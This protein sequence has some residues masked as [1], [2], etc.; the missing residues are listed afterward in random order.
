MKL[1]DR[2]F[3]LNNQEDIEVC[4]SS[5]DKFKNEKQSCEQEVSLELPPEL[6][7]KKDKLLKGNDLL[8]WSLLASAVSLLLYRAGI[9]SKVVLNYPATPALSLP[10]IIPID[11]SLSFKESL[12]QLVITSSNGLFLISVV[13]KL[14]ALLTSPLQI[15]KNQLQFVLVD[16]L[17]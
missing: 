16:C 13:M 1:I 14:A 11:P 6:T 2:E 3:W 9:G 7:L 8:T 12:I 17:Q 4:L 10:V 5:L 15:V